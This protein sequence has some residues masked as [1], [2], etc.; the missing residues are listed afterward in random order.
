MKAGVEPGAGRDLSAPER[1][2]LDR[3]AAR[4]RGLRV[5]L[6][7]RR[8]RHLALLDLRRHRRLHRVRRRRP[9]AARLPRRAPGPRA[10]RQGRGLG[11]GGQAAR[12]RGRRARD[13]RADA[14]DAGLLLGRRGRLAPP[15]GLLRRTTRASGAT[16]TG[17]RSPSRGTAIIYGRSDSTINRQG[18]R[19]GTSEIYRAVAGGPRG[20]RRARRRRP[21]A[22]GPR[23]GCRSS[24]SSATAR[25]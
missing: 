15:R 25:S 8:R 1:D 3:L 20:A 17:S 14:V 6:R 7:A 24:S 10:R 12:R 11:R 9:A 2:R 21:A 19:M 22:R 4:A 13:H 18:V 5:D 23:A 16:A